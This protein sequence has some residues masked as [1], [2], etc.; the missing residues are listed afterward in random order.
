[1]DF[2]KVFSSPTVAGGMVYFGG[3][4]R[5]FYALD[6]Q[7]GEENWRF[8]AEGMIESSPLIANGMVYFGSQDGHLYALR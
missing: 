1:M 5:F 8:E 4:D 7:T 2:S 6:S 3:L